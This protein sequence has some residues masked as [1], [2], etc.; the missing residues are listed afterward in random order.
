MSLNSGVWQR[1]ALFSVMLVA[2]GSIG[3]GSLPTASADDDDDKPSP[4]ANSRAEDDALFEKLDENEDGW[5]SGTEATRFKAYDKDGNGRVTKVEFLAGRAADRKSNP[6]PPVAPPGV[7]D[8]APGVGPQKPAAPVAQND[9]LLPAIGGLSVAQ[10]AILH[11]HLE[12]LTLA[13]EKEL[14]SAA[15]AEKKAL[16]ASSNMPVLTGYLQ[17]VQ[18]GMPPSEDR[19]FLGA[20]L[21]IHQLLMLQAKRLSEYARSRDEAHLA[22]CH[23]AAT[24]VDTR[25]KELFG[26]AAPA[27]PQSAAETEKVVQRVAV[28]G[29]QFAKAA[30]EKMTVDFADEQL[31]AFPANRVALQKSAESIADLLAKASE[32]F[33]AAAIHCETASKQARQAGEAVESKC[34][35]LKARSFRRLAESK[36]SF[37]K[38]VLLIGDPSIQSRKAFEEQAETLITEAKDLNDESQKLNTQ[39]DE[40][41]EK[42]KKTPAP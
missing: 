12:L 35:L 28:T 5:L 38:M 23:K 17:K 30:G 29:N 42:S 37:R 25:M 32:Q 3:I 39:A 9:A 19:K 14:I 1:G 41:Y 16:T 36:D 27:A 33:R 34:W 4:A 13:C 10:A 7:S 15:E 24:A 31:N 40:L 8:D 2:A 18:A 20:M 22:A 21:E 11:K 26:G 6:T